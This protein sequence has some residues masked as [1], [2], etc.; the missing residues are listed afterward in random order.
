MRSMRIKIRMA[1]AA[2]AIFSLGLLT[3]TGAF[4]QAPGACA[5]EIAMLC[6]DI[7]PGGGAVTQCL[8][9]H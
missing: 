9:E 1:L 7:Q 2:G 3:A 4:A 5:D 6:A 8:Q